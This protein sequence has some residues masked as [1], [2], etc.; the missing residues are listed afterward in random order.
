[1]TLKFPSEKDPDA[2][3]PYY[4]DWE[5]Y[6]E[7]GETISTSVWLIEG[8]AEGTW[9]TGSPNDSE[10]LAIDSKSNT[11]TRATIWLSGGIIDTDYE[12][13]NRIT[14]TG[15]ITDDRTVKLRVR[16]Q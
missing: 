6:L 16:A 15:G 11:T 1:M 5:D 4:V 12:I 2:V 13:T 8:I 7:N 9:P 14:T 3:K 10:T